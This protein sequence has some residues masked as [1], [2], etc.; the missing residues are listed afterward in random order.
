[1][2]CTDFEHWEIAL[3]D[4]ITYSPKVF[5]RNDFHILYMSRRLEDLTQDFLRDS[6][7]QSTNI[8]CSFIRLGRGATDRAIRGGSG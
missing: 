4:R 5:I 7:V 6:R 3:T 8:Q 1:M 2:L